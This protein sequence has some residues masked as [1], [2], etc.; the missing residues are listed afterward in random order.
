MSW[1][2]IASG[3]FAANPTDMEGPVRV[4]VIDAVLIHFLPIEF[5]RPT[6]AATRPK[7]YRI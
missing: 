1:K 5:T 7:L 4:V 3:L 6:R 2:E